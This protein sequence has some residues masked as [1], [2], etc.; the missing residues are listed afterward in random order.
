M[1]DFLELEEW[2]EDLDQNSK[3]KLD[4]QHTSGKG[5]E[6]LPK[7]DDI[8]RHKP[9]EI[10]RQSSYLVSLHPPYAID[11]QSL[12]N[13]DLHTPDSIARHPPIASIDTHV[14]MKNQ[15]TRLNQDRLR[16]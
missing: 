4:D 9:D 10:D 11:R 7:T 13:T 2:L 5:L 15:D 1:E 16:R 12:S 6:I 3:Q 8:D 14:W